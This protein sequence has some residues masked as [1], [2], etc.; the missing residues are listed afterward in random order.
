MKRGQAVGQK[1]LKEVGV[2]VAKTLCKKIKRGNIF[3][4][5]TGTNK[6]TML[7]TLKFQI[8]KLKFDNHQE[9]S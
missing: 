8:D 9:K 3:R 5:L 6:Q 4:R 7:G 1:K 2:G